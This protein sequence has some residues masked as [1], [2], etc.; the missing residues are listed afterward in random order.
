MIVISYDIS[1]NKLRNRFSKYIRRFGSRMQFSVY[2]IDNSPRILDN[3]I[4]DVENRFMPEFKE[5]DSVILF[6][7]SKSCKVIRMGYAAH[8]DEDLIIV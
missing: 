1:D 3:I 7:M 5:K 2:E 6:N 4:A 8:D